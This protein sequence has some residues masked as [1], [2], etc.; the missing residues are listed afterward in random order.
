M[1]QSTEQ[2]SMVR[3]SSCQKELIRNS[4]ISDVV[5]T[6]N[7]SGRRDFRR[8]GLHRDVPISSH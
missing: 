1:I 6:T 7:T 2:Q 4:L 5:Y 3:L 8:L